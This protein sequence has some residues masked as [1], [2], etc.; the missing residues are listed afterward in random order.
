MNVGPQS[1][2]KTLLRQGFFDCCELTEL[3]YSV[4]LNHYNFGNSGGKSAIISVLLNFHTS[5]KKKN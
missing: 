2:I 5:C 4:A 3:T 1:Y